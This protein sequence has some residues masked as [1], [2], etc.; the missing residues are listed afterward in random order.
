[1]VLIIEILAVIPNYYEALLI[2]RN[3]VLAIFY[4]AHV[5]YS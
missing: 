2:N 1:M 3:K 5:D 4:M